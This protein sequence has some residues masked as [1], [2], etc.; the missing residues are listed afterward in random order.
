[1]FAKLF[2]LFCIF[3]V[4]FGTAS[5]QLGGGLGSGGLGGG[6]VGDGGVE[7][8]HRHKSSLIKDALK[9]AAIGAAG[10]AAAHALG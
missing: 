5:A 8:P 7:E 9:G 3:L 6:S 2:A 10:G 1:M 4:I